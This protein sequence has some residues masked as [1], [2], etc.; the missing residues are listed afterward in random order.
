MTKLLVIKANPNKTE[1]SFGLT[2]GQAFIEEYKAAHPT[3]TVTEINLFE[4]CI[5]EIDGNMLAARGV[6]AQG[7]PFTDLSAEQQKQIVVSRTLLEQFMDHDKYVFITPLWNLTFPARMKL[8]LDT[9]CVAGTTFRYTE[10]GPVGL[11][12]GKKA[13]HIHAAGGIYNGETYATRI[14]HDILGL[15]G[16]K[17]V[18]TLCIEGHHANP[19]KAN[20]I[21]E[22][23]KV[24]ATTIAQQ[25]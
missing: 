19:D 21:K 6:L 17:D 18:Q 14:L 3:D 11:L 4:Q 12:E 25:F 8:Y 9:L 2:V 24:D 1:D 7:T 16:I 5:P 22:K 20:D 15:I 13:L 23:G 10:N